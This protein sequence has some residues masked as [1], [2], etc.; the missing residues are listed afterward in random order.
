MAWRGE[1]GA[2]IMP[3]SRAGGV[4]MN[5][6]R[7]KPY[8][9]KAGRTDDVAGCQQAGAVLLANRCALGGARQRARRAQALRMHVQ[10]RSE[11]LSVAGRAEATPRTGTL[12]QTA[13]T[14]AWQP[15]WCTDSMPTP[16]QRASCPKDTRSLATQGP[17]H[18]MRVWLQAFLAR[19]HHT[20]TETHS[21][22]PCVPA[23]ARQAGG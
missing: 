15:A 11:V 4:G 21:Q 20:K 10:F 9:V 8:R 19:M 16:L 7:R 17:W 14:Q 23:R 1:I 13:R 2:K 5:E 18:E 3:T 12:M 6:R 22:Q